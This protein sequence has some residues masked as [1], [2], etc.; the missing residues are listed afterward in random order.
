MKIKLKTFSRPL[1]ILSILF[2]STMTNGQLVSS[3]ILSN[4]IKVDALLYKEDGTIFGSGGWNGSNIYKIEP[5]G[6]VSIHTS[7][8]VGI[9]DMV[10]GENDTIIG[11]SYQEG[12]LLKIAPDGSW[13]TFIQTSVG[14]ASLYRDFNG[15]IICTINPGLASPN[16]GQVIKVTP[17]GS[18]STFV[19]GGSINK[20]SGICQ[21]DSANYYI[22]NLGDG[23]ITKVK[24]DG[25]KALFAAVPA[26]GNWKIGYIKFWNGSFYASAI[27]ENKIYKVTLNGNVSLYAGDG[28][29]INV[30]GNVPNASIRQPNGM[31][32]SDD[33]LFVI[34]GINAT[35]KLRYIMETSVSGNHIDGPNKQITMQCFP[36]PFKTFV[37]IQY[38]LKSNSRID[39]HILNSFGK[40]ERELYS[41]D[42]KIGNHHI[43]WDGKDNSGHQVRSGIYFIKI[44]NGNDTSFKKIISPTH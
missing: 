21:D 36:N 33:T 23:L 17:Q 22:S 32:I 31:E 2:I 9:V 27:S 18:V 3:R 14:I 10:W 7:G 34:S 44:S 43:N 12:K 24:P 38:S 4:S 5:N 37:E 40:I 11:S 1:I 20:P 28:N 6:N 15:D 19:S 29:P 8:L 26:T 42:Q 30:D 16:A 39:I 25:S 35:N 13:S 41:E